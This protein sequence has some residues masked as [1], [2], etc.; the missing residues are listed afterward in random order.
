MKVIFSNTFCFFCFFST[1]AQQTEKTIKYFSSKQISEQYSVLKKDKTVKQGEYIAYFA[2]PFDV[3]KKVKIDTSIL[4]DYI[5]IKGFYENGKKKGE[6]IE[7]TKANKKKTK[8]VYDKDKKIGIW[9][10]YQ[11]NG[12]IMERFDYTKNERLE[13]IFFLPNIPYPKK[14][15]F[16]GVEGNVTV[17]YTINAEC[18]INDVKITKSLNEECDNAVIQMFKQ[19]LAVFYPKYYFN[20]Q[21]KTQNLDVNFTLGF[22]TKDY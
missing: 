18:S 13:P 2:M 7:Y 17:T 8:G 16:S 20:C 21:Q 4:K 14:A 9:E 19:T 6:W 22:N 12:L 15:R 1:F 11:E 5:K 10:T 3:L